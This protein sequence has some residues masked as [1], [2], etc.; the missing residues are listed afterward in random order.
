MRSRR[1]PYP[2][3]VTAAACHLRLRMPYR[4]LGELLGAHQST[5]SLAVRRLAPLLEEHRLTPAG[6]GPRITT[7]SELREHA[8]TRGITLAA[9]TDPQAAPNHAKRR[10]P[11]TRHTQS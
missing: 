5:I 4:L 6:S 9:T 10:P 11:K 1:L 7:L 8:A 3:I 2:A